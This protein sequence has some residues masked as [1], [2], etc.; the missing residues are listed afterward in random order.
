MPD[1]YKLLLCEYE[2]LGKILE[3]ELDIDYAILFYFMMLC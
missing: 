2:S 1:K 3:R